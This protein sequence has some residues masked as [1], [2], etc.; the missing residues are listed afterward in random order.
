MS[1]TVKA[2]PNYDWQKEKH[3][4]E[5]VRLLRDAASAAFVAGVLLSLQHH[6]Q[7]P[8]LEASQ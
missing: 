8:S 4:T 5:I 7:Q 2:R 1:K 6:L 3:I